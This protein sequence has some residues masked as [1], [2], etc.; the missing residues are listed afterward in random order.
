MGGMSRLR[1]TAALVVLAALGAAAP[2]QTPAQWKASFQSAYGI[3]LIYTTTSPTAYS[4]T[5]SVPPTSDYAALGAYMQKAYEQI[6]KYTPYY[7]Q[8]MQLFR[9]VVCYDLT[10]NGQYRAAAPDP[11]THTLF[12]DYR[13]GAYSPDYQRHVVNHELFHYMMGIV[14]G[15][16]YWHD[17]T[18]GGYNYPGFQYGSGGVNAQD[19]S[20]AVLNHPYLGF[21]DGYATSA[22][23]EDMAEIDAMRFVPAEASQLA[24]W[25]T[26]DPYLNNKYNRLLQILSIYQ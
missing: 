17:A 2:A 7:R 13:R 9:V 11:S 18:F 22:M 1:P 12:L 26:N 8:N 24:S 25:R 20:Y 10:V 19:P 6:G 21:V 14:K 16:M 23:E 4:L 5:Y 3:N 15:S